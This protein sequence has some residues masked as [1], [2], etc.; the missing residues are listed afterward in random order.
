[1]KSNESARMTLL[2]LER[3]VEA[4]TGTP[5]AEIRRRSPV[6]H[7]ALVEKQHG[8]KM[9]FVSRFSV[10]GRGHVLRDRL[11]THEEIEAMLNE[12]LR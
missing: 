8:S 12:V 7:R 2:R 11:K 4:I 9:R 1:M 6:E 3:I 10:I 5:V